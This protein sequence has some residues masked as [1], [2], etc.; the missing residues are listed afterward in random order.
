MDSKQDGP[1][2]FRVVFSDIDNFVQCMLATRKSL[3][4]RIERQPNANRSVE[5]NHLIKDG[6]LKKGSIVKLTSYQPNKV[7]DK[8][9]IIVLDL[10][11]LS[12]FGECEKIGE[13]VGLDTKPNKADDKP[14]PAGI[15]GSSMYGNRQAEQP[16]P[17]TRSLPSRSTPTSTNHSS[18][19]PI[20]ALSTWAH[21][22]TIKAR[23]T[24]KTAIKTWHKNTGEGKLFSV[25]LLDESGEIRAT[26][27]GDQVDQLYDVFQEGGVYYISSPCAVKIANKRFTN[28]NNDYELTF[29][30]DTVVERVTDESDVPQVRFNFTPI[31]SLDRIEKDS[32][33]DTIGILKE[34]GEISEIVSKTTSKPYSKRDLTLVDDTL[35][36]VRLT[37]WGN[38]AKEFNADPDSVIAFKG[39]KV[40]DFGG[41]SLSLLSSG[42]M[43]L[44]PDI[45][46]AHKLKGWY[47][48][49]G[50]TS[51]Y[52]THV[53]AG[54]S[55]PSGRSDT[56]K[57]I[58]QV[59][60]EN[61]G[62]SEQPDFFTLK[63]TVVFI[64][65]ENFAYPACLTEGCNK[66]VVEIDPGQWRCERCDKNHPQ[67]NWRYILS[68]SVNDYTGQLWL[69]GF[70]DTGRLLIGVDANE[71]TRLRDEGEEAKFTETFNDANCKTM[72]FRVKAK[73]DTFQDQQ[74]YALLPKYISKA[75]H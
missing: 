13:P 35:H 1:E 31:G 30:R 59:R 19:Y 57:T 49:A 46:E 37:I 60:D 17:Q 16:Q 65:K 24:H 26:G 72:I 9:I 54:L 5:A 4:R 71:L 11:V 21:K 25:N 58:A 3:Y 27:F 56:Y 48:A 28:L 7:K 40:S 12:Q 39:V 15:S 62:M 68:V 64:K 8:P 43:A 32:T 61:L 20:E 52:Q 67:P 44:D 74:R 36:S 38:M 33:I 6:A 45:D 63:A 50:Q 23:C 73:M 69:S 70:D 75:S 55:G 66:K 2:R 10:Q 51:T 22:W 29:E 34:V 14:Q 53:Q 18:L 42:S 47:E 41:R